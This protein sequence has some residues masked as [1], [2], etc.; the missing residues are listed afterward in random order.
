MSTT[1]YPWYYYGN[2]MLYFLKYHEYHG[3]IIMVISW[4][5][6]FC[7][8]TMNTMVLPW[9]IFLRHHLLLSSALLGRGW[10]TFDVP[11]LSQGAKEFHIPFTALCY[12]IA[13]CLYSSVIHMHSTYSWWCIFTALALNTGMCTMWRKAVDSL[14]V[15][16]SSMYSSMLYLVYMYSV[17]N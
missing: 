12:Y 17:H 1:V 4:V 11:C 6:G 10:V 2:T 5:P 8:N 9:Y 15:P 7:G 13:K 3:I 16:R 14:H